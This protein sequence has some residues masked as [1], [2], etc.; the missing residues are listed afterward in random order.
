[1]TQIKEGDP[2]ATAAMSMKLHRL[3]T[4]FNINASGSVR[5]SNQDTNIMTQIKEGDP[6]ATAAMSMKLC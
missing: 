2:K 5:R 1:M 3:M 4:D 6:K